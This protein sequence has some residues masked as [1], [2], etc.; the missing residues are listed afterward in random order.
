MGYNVTL[1]QN[2]SR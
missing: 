1:G 2:S